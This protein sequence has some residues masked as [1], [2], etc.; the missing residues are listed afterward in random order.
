MT[1]TVVSLI[2]NPHQNYRLN[3]Q[4][5]PPAV[6]IFSEYVA[7]FESNGKWKG[8]DFI[9]NSPICHFILIS[10]PICH[11]NRWGPRG[12]KKNN[13]QS[14]M[15]GIHRLNGIRRDTAEMSTHNPVRA[16]ELRPAIEMDDHSI[17]YPVR[18][19]LNV[20]GLIWLLD[21]LRKNMQS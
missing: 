8:K 11:F 7:F 4:N 5:T 1:I 17:H 14:T 15:N 6:R 12:L 2:R 18:S 19:F 16:G 21:S 9:F 20:T 13:Q 10:T 3:M